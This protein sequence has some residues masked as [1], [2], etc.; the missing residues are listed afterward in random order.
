[1]QKLL[2]ASVLQQGQKLIR[3]GEAGAWTLGQSA[4]DAVFQLNDGNFLKFLIEFRWQKKSP[5]SVTKAVFQYQLDRARH[6]REFVF[7]Y[8]Y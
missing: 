5:V 3:Y 1:M 6:S 4:T 7:R 8:D 2:S